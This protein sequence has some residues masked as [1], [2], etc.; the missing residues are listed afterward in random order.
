L[1]GTDFTTY[2]HFFPP[3]KPM[4]ATLP[5]EL[6]GWRLP[7]PRPSLGIEYVGHQL[8]FKDRTFVL[9][10]KSQAAPAIGKQIFTTVRDNQTEVRAR[11]SATPE[12]ALKTHPER[13]ART[14]ICR[15]PHQL[16]AAAYTSCGAFVVACIDSSNELFPHF[17][18]VSFQKPLVLI[19]VGLV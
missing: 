14:W 18:K 2:K 15:P 10:H 17:N 8:C 16:R 5:T 7:F 3:K 6:S 12:R 19:G 13:L 4:G 9:V 11:P 1:R